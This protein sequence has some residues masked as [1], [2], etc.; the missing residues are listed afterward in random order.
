MAQ[1]L[2][3]AK[4]MARLLDCS[5]VTLY[6]LRR[7]GVLRAGVYTSGGRGALVRY[8]PD[9]VLTQLRERRGLAMP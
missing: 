7:R 3:C 4:E 5:I 1:K 9:A 2:V 8:D 6:R